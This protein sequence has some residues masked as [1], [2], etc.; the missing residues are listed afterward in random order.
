M[1]GIDSMEGQVLTWL[2][3]MFPY[4]T[5]AQVVLAGSVEGT[6]QLLAGLFN[7]KCVS[8][9]PAAVKFQLALL[10]VTVEDSMFTS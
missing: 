5:A 10:C 6:L 7:A 3:P 1:D 9:E 2:I 4:F 8:T